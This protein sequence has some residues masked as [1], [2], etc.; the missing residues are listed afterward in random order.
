VAIGDRV[1]DSWR[2]KDRD[3]AMVFQTYALYP[4]MTVAENLSLPLMMRRLNS[5][6]RA[7]LFKWLLPDARR[8]R[9]AIGREIEEIAASLELV[10]HL[11]RKPAQ[12]SGGQRQRVA[13]ARAMVRRP[14]VFLMDEPLSNLDSTL[15]TQMRTEIAA[16]RRKL[17]AAFIYVTHDQTEA[18]TM[19]D[20]VA[21]MFGGSI[22]QIGSP[23]ALYTQPATRQVAEFVGTPR[24][25]MLE[26]TVRE[27]SGLDICDAVFPTNHN[28]PS[29]ARVS[30]GIRPE[31]LRMSE[32]GSRAT[33][34]GRVQRVE[35]MGNDA[36]A[37]CGVLGQREPLVIRLSPQQANTLRSES[38]VHVTA[39][40]DS[41]L[42]FDHDGNAIPGRGAFVA[43]R[44]GQ[45]R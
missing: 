5:W 26:G 19:S 38:T 14:A 33:L 6:Q 34:T 39:E 41:L 22:V 35:Y 44:T 4:H 36:L 8:Q 7:P 30:V 28:V 37:Y 12:L 9:A 25:N 17:T 11:D 10:P 32:R 16:L 18:M 40:R 31:H 42:I 21:V 27:D 2:P 1:V 15:R 29:G 3:I 20:R 24:I 45:R 13:L 43:Q 23:Q